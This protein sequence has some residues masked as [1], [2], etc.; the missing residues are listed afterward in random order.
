MKYPNGLNKEYKKI[1]K[2]GNRGMNLENEI[3]ETNKY[4]LNN[5]IAVIKF[6]DENYSNYCLAL[7]DNDTINQSS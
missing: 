2:T 7:I 3:N 6:S 1:T 5:D 4:Y